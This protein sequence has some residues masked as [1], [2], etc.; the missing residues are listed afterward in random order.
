VAGPRIAFAWESLGPSHIDRIEAA[1]A[2]GYGVTAIEFAPV[3][4]DYR[5]ESGEPLG[6]KRITLT[7]KAERI[8]PLLLAWRLFRAV[9]RDKCEAAFLCHYPEPGVFLAALLLRLS[10]C[11]V[12]A[13]IDSKFDDY[14]RFLSREV[15]KALLL[16]PYNGV[17][18]G[19]RR[20]ADY[21]HFLGFRRRTVAQGFD[22]LDLS[23]I[24]R[25]GGS[26]LGPD[27]AERDFLIVARLVEKKNLPFAL[28]AYASWSAMA[29][30]PRQLRI[31]GYG[32]MEAELR[33]LA[34]QLGIEHR[35]LFM[36][37]MDS[38]EVCR[39]MRESLCLILPSIEEQ[40]GLVVIEALALGLPV[41]VSANAGAVDDLIDN[42]VNGWIVDPYRPEAL[43]SAMALLDR[44]EAVWRR[45]SE[46][47][48]ASAERGDTRH[49]VAGLAALLGRSALS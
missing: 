25:L 6:A 18:V 40:F 31:I 5:W 19:S 49:F 9:R 17:L 28:R 45:A 44:E 30:H 12:F 15:G 39:A 22:M 21:M 34:A 20:T 8:G 33:A 29:A 41:L 14:P 13:M 47:A 1:V 3:S 23:R 46:A 7:D 32:A 38:A 11:R 35:V 10:G 24:R 27:H 43:V 4:R 26:G 42:G 37:A 36:G 2:A 16:A 48:A